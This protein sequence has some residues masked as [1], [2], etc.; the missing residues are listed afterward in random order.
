MFNSTQ[1]KIKAL[2]KKIVLMSVLD[3]PG[4]M[5][6]A[7]WAY[8]KFA[9]NGEP[10]HP[11]LTNASVLNILLLGGIAIVSLCA[12]QIVKLSMK[13]TELRKTLLDEVTPG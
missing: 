12:M 9:S 5:M 2:D 6:L 1:D 7:L 8:A 10:F 13:K 3:T 4:M 11:L